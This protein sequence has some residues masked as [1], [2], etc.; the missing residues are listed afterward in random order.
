[1]NFQSKIAILIATGAVSAMAYPMV[2]TA[3]PATGSTAAAVS[4]KFQKHGGSGDFS[5]NPG[6]NSSGYGNGVQELSAA[7]A[8]GETSATAKSMSNM[9]GTSADAAGYS[10][11]VFLQYET[12]ND[13]VKNDSAAESTYQTAYQQQAAIEFA[14]GQKNSQSSFRSET[15]GVN[16]TRKGGK[17]INLSKEEIEIAKAEKSSEASVKL[18]ATAGSGATTAGRNT[19][20][21]QYSNKEVG[22]SYVYTGSS[23]GLQFLP[24]IVK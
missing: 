6:A 24:A 9:H 17:L 13:L 7:V 16:V 23:T 1:M 3:G 4:I 2:A 14:A 11:P 5:I 10:A 15:E 22:T 20:S 19:T 21:S 8:T 12:H 18:A